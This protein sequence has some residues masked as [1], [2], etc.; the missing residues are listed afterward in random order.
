MITIFYHQCIIFFALGARYKYK[1]KPRRKRGVCLTEWAG[2]A[3]RSWRPLLPAKIHKRSI[4]HASKI[5]PR[6]LNYSLS[7]QV[8]NAISK[9][10]KEFHVSSLVVLLFWMCNELDPATL[11]CNAARLIVYVR[12]VTC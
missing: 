11:L 7:L 12:D 8:T 5:E 4:F 9:H 1:L 10:S 3:R 6:S 2:F